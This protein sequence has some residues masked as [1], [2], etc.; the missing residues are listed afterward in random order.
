MDTRLFQVIKWLGHGVYHPLTHPPCSIKIKER[1]QLYLYSFV[2]S[3]QV[4][5]KTLPLPLPQESSDTHDTYMI[6]ITFIK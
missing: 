5:G 2:P 3:W 4:I 6:L 1:V